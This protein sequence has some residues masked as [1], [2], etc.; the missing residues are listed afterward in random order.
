MKVVI[1]PDSFKDSLSAQE[2]AQAIASGWQQ[3]FPNAEIIQCPMADGG[4]GSIE[5][6]LEVCS[7]EWREQMVQGPLG[8]PVL[9]KWGW[10]ATEKIAIIEMAQASGIQLVQPADRDACISST[11][12]TGELILAALDAGAKEIVLTV[13][14]SAT[15]DAGTGLL[16]ALGATFLDAKHNPLAAGGIALRNL[17]KINLDQLDPRI[18][19]TQFRLAADVT[20]PLCGTNGA[21]HIFGPQKG[22]SPQQVLELDQALS[23]FADVTT[24][25]LGVDQRHEAGAGAA[26]GL[27]FAARTFLKAEF[28]SGVEVIAELNQLAA[29][30]QGADWVITGEGKFDEQTLN[31]KTPFG[32]AKI[33]QAANIPVIVIT[34]TLGENYQALYPHGVTAAFSLTSGPTSL[35]EAC[36][37]AAELIHARTTD[38]ARLIQSSML[39]KE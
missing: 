4:E 7:G 8:E 34:G 31:G 5:A 27:G 35:E 9:A 10:L 23:H 15:N 36:Q 26:G 6:V 32:V 13:G 1:A 28:R 24:Q 21:S 17:A 25:L 11:F 12:G 16:T 3:V 2:I 14:G 29:K 30:I 20:N 19:Q 37:N 39:R 22:A 18:Q 38:I 33:A